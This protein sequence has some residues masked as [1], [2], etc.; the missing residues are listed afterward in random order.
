MK[1][2]ITIL[3]LVWTSVWLCSAAWAQGTTSRTYFGSN[4][5]Q[6]GQQPGSSIHQNPTPDNLVVTVYGHDNEF[7]IEAT[8]QSDTCGRP[9][10][11]R[12]NMTFRPNQFTGSIGGP[13]LRCTNQDLKDSCARVGVTLTDYYEVT[14]T[15]TVDRSNPGIYI[16]T[17]TYP[18]AVWVKED[19][20]EA[21]TVDGTEMIWLT[22]EPPT[23]PPL[24]N[25]QIWDWAWDKFTDTVYKRVRGGRWLQNRPK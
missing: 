12:G 8:S 7:A 6:G 11:I 14:F 16:I 23:P 17:I 4:G 13:M 5:P 24:T 1:R 19:C 15:G 20:K 2:M 9:F 10:Y 21:R 18:Y 25:K 22:Y 3:T